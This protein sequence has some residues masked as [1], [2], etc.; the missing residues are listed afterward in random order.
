MVTDSYIH[1][2]LAVTGTFE[3]QKS[4]LDID[5]STNLLKFSIKVREVELITKVSQK[6]SSLLRGI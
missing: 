4:D 2:L 6:V 5:I 3:Q 1:V